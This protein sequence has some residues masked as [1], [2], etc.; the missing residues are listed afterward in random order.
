MIIA[1]ILAMGSACGKRAA[2]IPPK[3]RV[4]QRIVLDGFQRGNQV[5]LSWKMPAR[6]APVGNVQ[7][8]SRAD[9]YR[10]AEPLTSPLQL[11]EEEFAN[12]STLVAALKIS[13]TDFGS[14][15]LNYKD[16]LQFADQPVRLRYALRFVNASGQKAAFSNAIV[17]EPAAKIAS[18]PTDLKAEASQDAVH[19]TWQAPTVNI[20][21]TQPVSI[22]GY[23]IYRSASE[24]EPAKLLNRT[25]FTGTSYSDEFFDFE[26]DY[27]YFVRAVSLGVGSEPVESAESNIAKFRGVDTFA[28]SAPAAITVA[29]A[30]GTISIFWAVNPE[31]D[32]VGYKVY[33]STDKDLPLDKWTPLTPEMLTTNTYQDSRVETG[34]QYFY[35]LTATD[36]AGNISTLSE[37]VSETAP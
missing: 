9:I 11:S 35:Y 17:I 13:N 29:A 14:K 22:I 36:K 1:V 3:E 15:S 28:P 37:I 10:L 12:R 4:L 20:D 27:F 5:I 8:I 30:P 23:N 6:N 21:Q 18:N 33:R 19:L 32:V 16:E 7:N 26:K 34:K 31:K 24:K 25:P 2:P